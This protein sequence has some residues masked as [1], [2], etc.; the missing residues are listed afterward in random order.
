MASGHFPDDQEPQGVSGY[1]LARDIGVTQKT[2]WLMAYRIHEVH[3]DQSEAEPDSPIEADETYTG[4]KYAN[5]H[6]SKKPRVVR[7]GSQD[8]TPEIVVKSR[9]TKKVK[10][11]ITRIGF[12]HYPS[13]YG[14]GLKTLE[15]R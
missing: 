13:E 6:G 15:I 11:R 9:K 5:T 7:D 12:K 8:K 1:K 2:A 10:A 14:S 3:E 4:G